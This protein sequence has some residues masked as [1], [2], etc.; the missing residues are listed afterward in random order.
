MKPGTTH[1]LMAMAGTLGG[2]IL[3]A[4]PEE[5]YAVGDTK[6]M[7]VLAVLFAQHAEKAVDVLHGEN[8]A[9]RALFARAAPLVGGTLGE[10]LAAASATSDADLKLSTV[11]AANDMLNALLIEL[12][13]DVEGR[14]ADWA[15]AMDREIWA[16][17]KAGADGRMLEMPAA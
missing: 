7:A 6:M 12:H 14:E 2:R 4:L 8:A 9:L 3:P 16:L 15:K 10:R 13:A 17:L 11:E 1:H 5:S